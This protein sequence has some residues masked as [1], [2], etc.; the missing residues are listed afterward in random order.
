MKPGIH[1]E[2]R[3]SCS[4]DTSADGSFLIGSAG[5]Q[6]PYPTDGKTYPT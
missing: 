4:S 6:D 5:R 1:P 2:Y 3:P